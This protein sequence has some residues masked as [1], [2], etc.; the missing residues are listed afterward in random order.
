MLL[1]LLRG[2]QIDWKAI[3]EKHT[4]RRLCAECAFVGCRNDF[5][6]SQFAR[7]DGRHVCTACVADRAKAGT[8]VQ[9]TTCLLWK[10]AGA[11]GKN[12]EHM[13]VERRVCGACEER[14]RCRGCGVAKDETAFTKAE[15]TH[16]GKTNHPRGRCKECMQRNQGTKVCRGCQ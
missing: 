3:E 11:F 4:P 5:A 10:P 12:V 9:C 8:P 16:A 2:D 6:P 13:R 1:K 15:W 14:R 7:K